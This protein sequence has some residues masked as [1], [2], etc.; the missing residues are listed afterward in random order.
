M[1]LVRRHTITKRHHRG[2]SLTE[3]AVVLPVL[4]LLLL[5]G[6]DFGRVFLGWITLNNIAREA[7]NFAGENPTAWNSANPDT[8]AQ[9]EY[10]RLIGADAQ[11][12]DCTVQNPLPTP[13]FPNGP[14]GVNEIGQPVRVTISCGFKL[15]TPI[16]GA[17]VGGTLPVTASAAFPIRNGAILGIPVASSVPYGTPL[18]TPSPTPTVPPGP[19]P[20]PSPTPNPNCIVPNLL[21]VKAVDAQTTWSAAGFLQ[22]VLFNPAFPATPPKGG[23]NITS[24]SIAAGTSALCVSTAITVTWK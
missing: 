3:F 4:L 7:A 12:I 22:P 9:A 6:I 2:Q 24:Q 15:I 11:P 14:D 17:L 5:F 8:A 18:P 16:M 1:Q 21:N 13:S 23:G 19:T 10:A 20:T